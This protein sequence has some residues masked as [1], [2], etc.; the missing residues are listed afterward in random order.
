[1]FYSK[2]TVMFFLSEGCRL[3]AFLSGNSWWSTCCLMWRMFSNR[4]S[5][6][7]LIPSVIDR[8]IFQRRYVTDIQ[9]DTVSARQETLLCCR[10][11]TASHTRHRHWRA[12]RLNRARS[13]CKSS[14]W[15]SEGRHECLTEARWH[16]TVYRRSCWRL[17]SPLT[18]VNGHVCHSAL[19]FHQ[20]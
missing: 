1:M 16:K 4:V 17:I 12:L 2:W 13:G 6:A 9:M 15:T 7:A 5:S 14:T 3:I 19:S 20:I 11:T 10:V 8:C 18:Y